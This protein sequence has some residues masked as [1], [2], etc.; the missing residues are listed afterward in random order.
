MNA[1][2]L[3]LAACLVL[4]LT[5]LASGDDTKPGDKAANKE[6]LVGVWEPQ[7]KNIPPGSSLEFTKDGK[8]KARFEAQG[9]PRTLDGSYKVEGNTLTVTFRMGDQERTDNLKIKTL[10]DQE[11]VTV[12]SMGKE[13][14]FKRKKK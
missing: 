4:G 13:D 1:P 5:A 6:K 2:K 10:T 7:G 11:L 14:T 3:V 8:L 9:K 12:D